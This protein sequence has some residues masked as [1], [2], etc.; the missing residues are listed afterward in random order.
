MFTKQSIRLGISLW[1]GVIN[2]NPLMESRILVEVAEEWESSIRSRIGAFSSKLQHLDPFY[3]KEEFA[4]SDKASLAQR[5]QAVH[6]LIAPHLRIL[7]FLASHFNATRLGSL[8]TQKIFQRLIVVSLEAQRN[9]A[10]HPLA[11][12]WHFQ[13][14]LFALRILRYSNGLDQ[15]AQWKLKD[16]I[17]S[18]ALRWF[19]HQPRWS[20]GGNRLQIKAESRLI[21]D[22]QAALTAVSSIGIKGSGSL[23]SLSRK[24][25]LLQL[26]LENEQMR[27]VVWLFPLDH[28]RRHMFSSG[29][30]G[31]PPESQLLAHLNVAWAE[32]PSLAIHLATRFQSL[33]LTTEVRRLLLLHPERA[34]AEPDA[35]Q[36]LLGPS[37]PNDVNTQ[38]K[39]FCSG[40]INL[41]ANSTQYLL[42]WAPVNPITASTYFL[43]EYCNHPFI[44][45]Y[46]MR[47]L[48]SHSVD[49]TFFYVPQIVQALRYD[50]LG[51]VQRYIIETAKFSQ[52]FA[53]QIIWNMKANAY[54]D[55]DSSI[56]GGA[57]KTQQEINPLIF[58]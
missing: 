27:L 43:P 57:M 50:A 8:H 26:L 13:L 25:E 1:L 40:P 15:A 19:S 34:V 37:L 16:T 5:Q 24:Q 22:V 32:D 51:Y 52:L 31:K 53:H 55:E 35:L 3:L 58:V 7:Q 42:Y 44:L 47:A 9:H 20:F 10:G 18:A 33:R 23:L 46:A 11:R 6:N 4:P 38:L 49:V 12:E 28:E 21:N 39:V 54:K 29:H 48:E 30:T 56:V 36:I 2:E 45:Q 14:V 17:L 41:K